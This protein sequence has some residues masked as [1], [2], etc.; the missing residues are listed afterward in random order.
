[1]LNAWHKATG[2]VSAAAIEVMATLNAGAARAALAAG[3]R[4]ATDVTGFGLLGHLAKL[5][6]ASGV[7]AIVDRAAVPLI[8]GNHE[9]AQAWYMPGRSRRN[10]AR[11]LPHTDTGGRMRKTCCCWLARRPRAGFWWPGSCR[12]RQ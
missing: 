6:S 4:C 1:V 9:A 11:V 8:E 7:T 10:L 2:S 3:I 5:G 12:E